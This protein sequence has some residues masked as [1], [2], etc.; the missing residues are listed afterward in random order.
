[1]SL[2]NSR[3]AL[4]Q[5]CME[6]LGSPVIR[7]NVS[8]EQVETAI[9]RSL[10]FW[11]EYHESAQERTYVA[12]PLTQEMIDTNTVLVPPNVQSVLQVLHP[13]AFGGSAGGESLFDFN[14]QFMAHNIW[15]IMNFGGGSGYFIARQYLADM[16]HML[17]PVP[18]FRFRSLSGKLHID[19]PL[20]QYYTPG[21]YLVAE[22]YAYLDEIDNSRIWEDRYLG[23]LSTAYIKKIWGSN[24][25]KFSGVTLPSG[26]TLN[27]QQIYDEAV[28]EAKEAEANIKSHMEPFG[29]I[30]A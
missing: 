22:V 26:I 12:I 5:H 3:I 2:P 23:E 9:S 10:Q 25:K 4:I 30:T 28:A 13:N 7:V 1:M 6:E 15:D 8:P 27:G 29:F 20:R 21:K 19:S 11:R 24:L 18:P 16:T 17:S 14:Y